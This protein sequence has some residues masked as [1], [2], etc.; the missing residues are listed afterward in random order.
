MEK[1]DHYVRLLKKSLDR[2]IASQEKL[3]P[4]LHNREQFKEFPDIVQEVLYNEARFIHRNIENIENKI[5]E[6]YAMNHEEQMK[7]DMTAWYVEEKEKEGSQ[8]Q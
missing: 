2:F 4:I 1:V 5:N 6:Y 3:V 7:W 8:K